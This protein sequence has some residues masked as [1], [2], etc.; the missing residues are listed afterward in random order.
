MIQASMIHF[1]SQ[2]YIPI[3]FISD[4][5][6][7]FQGKPLNIWYEENRQNILQIRSLRTVST[8]SIGLGNKGGTQTPPA[9]GSRTE[10]RSTISFPPS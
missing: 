6:L 7:T 10:P 8:Q 2:Y 9:T 3:N 4:D 1:Q 5:E